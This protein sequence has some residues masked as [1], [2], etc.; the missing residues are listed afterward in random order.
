MPGLE[1]S[2]LARDNADWQQLIKICALNGT[3]ICDE[4]GVYDPADPNDRLLLGV[5]GQ[6][7]EFE[8]HYLQARMR[9]GLL[10]KAARGELALPPSP[11]CSRCSSR[12]GQLVRWSRRSAARA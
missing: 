3:R 10:A 11:G 5:K 4:D 6:I 8:L 1:C 2:R 12:P 9:G 7:S